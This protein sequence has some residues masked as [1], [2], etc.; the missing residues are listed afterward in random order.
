MKTI[1]IKSLALINFKGIKSLNIDFGKE[2]N[3]H[4]ANG[5]GKTSIFDAFIWLFFG[6]DSTDR[7]NFEIKTLDSQNNVI[8]QID[9]EVSAVIEVDGEEVTVKRTFREKWVKKRG[10]LESEFGGNE[11]LYFWNDVPMT[12]RDYTNKI[13]SIV[14]ESVFKL[15]TSPTAFNS[16]KWQD[17]RQVLIDISGRVTDEDVAQGN[18]DFQNLL[19]KLTNKSLRNIKSRSRLP[20]VRLRMI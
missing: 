14:E 12:L 16:L 6:K 11:T 19:S 1:I 10:A 18:P 2:T 20:F 15:I 7:T 9:H 3:I 5:T 17:Q 13:S 8:P 4:G